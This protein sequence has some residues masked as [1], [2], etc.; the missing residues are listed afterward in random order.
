MKMKIIYPIILAS[1]ICASAYAANISGTVDASSVANFGTEKTVFNASDTTLNVTSDI[2]GFTFGAAS[3]VTNSKI[4]ISEDT[5]LT[6]TSCGSSSDGKEALAFGNTNLE[7]TGSGT[8]VYDVD[9]LIYWNGNIESNVVVTMNKGLS[10]NGTTNI[11]K[12]FTT[13]GYS[14]QANAKIC[15]HSGTTSMSGFAQW[16][17]NSYTEVKSGATLEVSSLRALSTGGALSNLTQTLKVGG[18]VSVSSNTGSG[19]GANTVGKNFGIFASK[20]EVLSGGSIVGT[21]STEGARMVIATSLSNAG[22]IDL[23]SKLYMTNNSTLT[24]DVG[25]NIM[26]EGKTSQ[27]ESFIQIANITY[28]EGSRPVVVDISSAN[29][30][31]TDITV[32]VNGTQELGGFNFYK[33]SSV[34]LNFEQGATLALGKLQNIDT[35]TGDFSINI[36]GDWKDNY[37]LKIFD[38]DKSAI[39][40]L[41]IK[42]NGVDIDFFVAEDPGNSGVYF[43]NQVPEPAE[44]AVIFGAVALAFVAYRRRK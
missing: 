43:I 10:I 37:S 6:M 13:N 1:A 17:Q 36:T 22:T 18:M 40:K 12:N 34:T 16:G 31:K 30:T 25:S 29:V 11:Y 42:S 19:S 21:D 4:N 23:A 3:S 14:G 5:T 9:G 2:S 41:N 26:T 24:L 32:N 33:D 8:L 28:V 15:I 39:E 7:L 27:K 20:V 35:Y 38:M 44:W